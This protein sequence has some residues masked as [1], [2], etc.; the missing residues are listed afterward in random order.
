MIINTLYRHEN[1]IVN[2]SQDLKPKKLPR[3]S[4]FRR[5]FFVFPI[6]QSNLLK[7]FQVARLINFNLYASKEP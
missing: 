2:G 5:G 6:L 4:Q 3:R 7:Y 1:R